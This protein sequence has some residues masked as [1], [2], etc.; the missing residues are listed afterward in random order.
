MECCSGDFFP[1][2][3]TLLLTDPPSISPLIRRLHHLPMNTNINNLTK[4]S[5]K[6]LKA[7]F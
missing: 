3:P 7:F 5:Q 2:R 6:I 4:R 1:T